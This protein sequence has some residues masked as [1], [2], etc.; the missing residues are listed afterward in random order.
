MKAKVLSF[1]LLIALGLSIALV[2]S[3]KK[4]NVEPMTNQTVQATHLDLSNWGYDPSDVNSILKAAGY[5]N[6]QSIKASD[7]DYPVGV[8][9]WSPTDD[10]PNAFVCVG[11]QYLCYVEVHPKKSDE[12]V[13]VV[14][15]TQGTPT[16]FKDV[17]GVEV[18]ENGNRHIIK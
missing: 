4:E 3:C 11:V 2:S 7:G 14:I 8:A 10:D 18:D 16:V 12:T 6:A 1:G 13:D 9:V 15:T 5:E 17:K